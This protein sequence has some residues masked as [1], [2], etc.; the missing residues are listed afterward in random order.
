MGYSSVK[1]TAKNGK[2]IR[3]ELRELVLAE[4]FRYGFEQDDDGTRLWIYPFYDFLYPNTGPFH[5]AKNIHTWVFETFRYYYKYRLTEDKKIDSISVRT[6]VFWD[7]KFR[8]YKKKLEYGQKHEWRL[9]KKI[10][11][12]FWTKAPLVLF[13]NDA[14]I[15][16]AKCLDFDWFEFTSNAYDVV[17]NMRAISDYIRN[18]CGIPNYYNPEQCTYRLY[19]DDGDFDLLLET[20]TRESLKLKQKLYDGGY[21]EL[22]NTQKEDIKEGFDYGKKSRTEICKAVARRKAKKD[23]GSGRQDKH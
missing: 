9:R 13:F 2:L 22:D 23:Q 15:L 16:D 11:Q 6:I 17:E 18:I 10:M 5:N 12:Y 4:A 19:F 3:A 8:I 21:I 20:V 14:V 1:N 7:K